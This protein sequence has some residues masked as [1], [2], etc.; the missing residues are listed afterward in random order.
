MERIVVFVRQMEEREREA[1]VLSIMYYADGAFVAVCSVR[2]RFLPA[3]CSQGGFGGAKIDLRVQRARWYV[4][5]NPL[6]ERPD[7]KSKQRSSG[8]TV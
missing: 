3:Q 5:A 4:T 2:T 7:K 6:H 8:N 1:I